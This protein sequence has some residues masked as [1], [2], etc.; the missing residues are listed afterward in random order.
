MLRL[1]PVQNKAA[2]IRVEYMDRQFLDPFSSP[3]TEKCVCVWG[4]R[5]RTPDDLSDVSTKFEKKIKHFRLSTA[6]LLTGFILV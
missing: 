2:E 3:Y 5:I 1:V 4:G 6:F